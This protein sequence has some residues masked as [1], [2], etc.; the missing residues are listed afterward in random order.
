MKTSIQ[1]IIYIAIILIINSCGF[2]DYGKWSITD[3]FAQ[4]IEGTSKILYKYDAWGGWDSN[5]TGFIVL[6]STE[7]FKIDLENTLP[8]YKLSGIPDKSIIK[9]IKHECYNSC[10]EEYYDSEPIF[11]PMKID[12]FQSE[13]INIEVITYQ[14]RGFSEKSRGLRSQFVFENFV[15][16]R[17]SIQFFN[18]NDT[19]S[20]HK[21]HLD[22]L[23]LAKGEAYLREDKNGDIVRIVI[24]QTTLNPNN[25]EIIETL[26]YFLSPASKLRSS[27]FTQ[28]GIFK[29]VTILE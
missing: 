3:L 2:A 4:K 8:F 7:T 9:G 22:E 5:V 24:N 6:D 20:I 13:E 25:N 21:T 11:S 28:R 23:K 1:F 15:E 12:N 27:D 17:D 16:T 10:A 26:T 29:T 14:Y 19:I 18:L